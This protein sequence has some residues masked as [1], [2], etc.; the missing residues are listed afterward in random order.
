MTTPFKIPRARRAKGYRS[1]PPAVDERQRVSSWAYSPEDLDRAVRDV[2]SER[3][4]G[5]TAIGAQSPPGL[6]GLQ[7]ALGARLIT[8]I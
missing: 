6:I 3:I 5:I 8:R 7:L 2:G 1:K 4:E